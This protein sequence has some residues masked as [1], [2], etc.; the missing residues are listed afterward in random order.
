MWKMRQ[1]GLATRFEEIPPNISGSSGEEI[2]ADDVPRDIKDVSDDIL[3]K[4]IVDEKN[5]KKFRYIK[6]ELDFHRKHNLALPIEYYMVGLERKRHAIGPIS[7]GLRTRA[8]AKCGETTPA[9]MAED[10]PGAPEKV[11]CE[12]CYNAEVA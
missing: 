11:Y 8:C 7:F 9:T 5:R 4:I 10:Y 6:K 3:T 12:S 1:F 2:R